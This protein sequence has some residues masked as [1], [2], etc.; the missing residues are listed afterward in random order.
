MLTFIVGIISLWLLLQEKAVWKFI[1]F[2]LVVIAISMVG[3]SIKRGD[4]DTL[5]LS[6][7]GGIMFALA[8]W[9]LLNGLIKLCDWLL[10]K[11][12]RYEREQRLRK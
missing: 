3:I 6:V 11:I 9:G 8:L 7:F 1:G 5:F 12:N 10:V 4:G 2:C